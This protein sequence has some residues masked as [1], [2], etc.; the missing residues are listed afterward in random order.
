MG[1]G[2]RDLHRPLYVGLPAHVREIDRI[3]RA[4]DGRPGG[5]ERLDP[6]QSAE[7]RD[8]LLQRS[9]GKDLDTAHHGRFGAVHSRN[10]GALHA[11]RPCLGH[12]RQNPVGVAQGAVERQLTQEDRVIFGDV[13][14]LS[15]CGQN[16]GGDRKIVHR[17]DLAHVRGRQVDGEATVR[18]HGAAVAD[19]R[20]RALPRLLHRRVGQTDDGVGGKPLGY[21][22]L[23][24]DEHAV[25]A[26]ER[27]AM[28]LGKHARILLVLG[29][30]DGDPAVGR[31]V[32][33]VP[34]VPD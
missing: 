22:D 33:V 27:A 12:H 18:K 20:A 19:G 2:G 4:I 15:G 13:A 28:H 34:G 25:K 31:P 9:H 23:D 17:P 21:V 29:R 14:Q 5:R 3:G 8:E 24:I 1:A 11:R 16:G 30:A 32:A 10:E 6:D 7:V 26:H